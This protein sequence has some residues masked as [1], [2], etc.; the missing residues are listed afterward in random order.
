M[1]GMD[2]HG[3][4]GKSMVHHGKAG[5]AFLFLTRRNHE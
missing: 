4:F 2:G 1:A 3:E 5:T